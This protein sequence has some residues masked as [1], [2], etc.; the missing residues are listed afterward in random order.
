MTDLFV[1]SK[2]RC[3]Q[4]SFTCTQSLCEL[5]WYFTYF[6][7]SN[8]YWKIREAATDK[9]K[10]DANTA[11]IAWTPNSMSQQKL[12]ELF[13]WLHG[14][15]FRTLIWFVLMELTELKPCSH[16]WGGYLW[17]FKNINLKV[18]FMLFRVSNLQMSYE[19]LFLDDIFLDDNKE[20]LFPCWHTMFLFPH[21]WHLFH[22]EVQ[23][24]TSVRKLIKE[25]VEWL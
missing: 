22:C 13:I 14:K 21:Q 11:R 10:A 20:K 9:R 12:R 4:H 2:R 7:N 5:T 23:E 1:I 8:L 25:L 15:Q 16:F 6:L 3:S 19:V 17:N 18:E 24:C